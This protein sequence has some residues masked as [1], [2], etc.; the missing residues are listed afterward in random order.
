RIPGVCAIVYFVRGNRVEIQPAVR[1]E[2][3]VDALAR[4]ESARAPQD[5]RG[6]VHADFLAANE[7]AK[8]NDLRAPARALGGGAVVAEAH[9]VGLWS[10][11]V[12]VWDVVYWSGAML[13]PPLSDT[14]YLM[15]YQREAGA[16]NV[17]DF[18]PREGVV[19]SSM[20]ALPSIHN[21]CG[22][23]DWIQKVLVPAGR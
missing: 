21:L 8:L 10:R 22:C 13:W 5:Q 4:A 2:I 15:A 9:G 1:R 12:G 17:A 19:K 11:G 6:L 14:W 16:V 3:D 18:S 20:M 23:N 7:S